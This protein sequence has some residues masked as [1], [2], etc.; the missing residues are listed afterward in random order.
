M[1]RLFRKREVFCMAAPLLLIVGFRARPLALVDNPMGV[2]LLHAVGKTGVCSYKRAAAAFQDDV[3]QGAA[4]NR[5]KRNTSEVETDGSLTRITTPDGDYWI[6]SGTD[7]SFLLAEDSLNVYLSGGSQVKPNDIVL[8]CGAN[9]GVFTKRALKAG[10]KLVVAIDPSPANVAAMQRTFA[11]E[12]VAGRVIVY[13]KGVWDKEDV[14]TMHVHENSALDSFVMQGRPE[15]EYKQTKK[16]DLP[17]TTID[18]LV[19]ELKLDRVD[20]IKMDIEGAERQ[21]LAGG[22]GTIKQWQPRMSVA[23]ENLGDDQYKV[24]EVIRSI[25]AGYKM[26]CG[27]CDVR[28]IY[29]IRP[30]ILYFY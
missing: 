19:A 2:A 23:A 27:P 29:E 9:V 24:P 22:A 26:E 15:D 17:L 8:D 4:N 14:L 28:S 25:H 6:P 3:K 11:Q 5:F 20:F 13:P 16:V 18:K 30:S 7:L 12:I 10:A 21:A 1:V